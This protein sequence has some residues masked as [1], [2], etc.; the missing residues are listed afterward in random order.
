[1][2]LKAGRYS[3]AAAIGL[4]QSVTNTILLLMGNKIAKKL[5]GRGIF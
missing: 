1:M 3:F 2:G 4:F 5:L